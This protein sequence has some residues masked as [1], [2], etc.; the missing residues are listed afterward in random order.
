MS[1]LNYKFDLKKNRVNYNKSTMNEIKTQVNNFRRSLNDECDS[2][3]SGRGMRVA[4][5]LYEENIQLESELRKK[6]ETIKFYKKEIDRLQGIITEGINELSADM[7]SDSLSKVTSAEIFGD[8]PKTR[9][10]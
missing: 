5:D 7:I 2:F 9:L 4:C 8:Y 1:S 6:D 3:G 10:V